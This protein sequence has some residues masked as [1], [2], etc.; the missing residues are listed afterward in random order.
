L[1]SFFHIIYV[2]KIQKISRNIT[3]F[4]GVFYVNDKYNRCELCK[5]IDSQL[6]TRAS[7]KGYS[8]GKLI[9]NFFYIRAN[10][11]ESLTEEIRLY[12]FSRSLQNFLLADLR[13]YIYFAI[14][15]ILSLF[16]SM[17]LFIIK[18][19]FLFLFLKLIANTQNLR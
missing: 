8:Y 13:N 5:L 18:Y 2:T 3:P 9:G 19:F 12:T 6:G 16:L 7:T 15:L 1:K 10:K 11:C 17:L 14:S 4:A